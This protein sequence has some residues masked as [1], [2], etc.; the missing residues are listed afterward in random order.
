[1]SRNEDRIVRFSGVKPGTYDYTI[2][3]GDDFFGEFENEEIEGGKV[4][5]EVRMRRSERVTMLEFA[6]GGTLRMRCD[7][8]LGDMELKVEGEESLNIRFSDTEQSEDEN[9]VVLPED[10]HE[11][12]LSPWLYEFVAV[13]I[14][15]QHTHPEGE[16][17]PATVSLFS[18]GSRSDGECDPRWEALKELK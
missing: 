7:R 13:R 2:V 4:V 16:C 3:L 18:D 8:C 15:M 5:F 11:L 12:D 17:D 10:A 6:F 14:P 9:T 1:M